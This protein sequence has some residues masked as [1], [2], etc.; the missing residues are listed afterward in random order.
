MKIPILCIGSLK[1]PYWR[2]AVAEYGKRLRR[3]CALEIQELPEQKLPANAGAAEEAAVIAA[4]S[5]RLSDKISIS[6][7]AHVIA[8]DIRGTEWSSTEL[9][10]RMSAWMLTGKSELI[11]LIGGSLGLSPALLERADD[12]LS[13]SPM[14]FPHQLMRVLLLEQV[15]RAFKINNHQPYHK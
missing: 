15:Y 4:E 12:R 8:P 11:F 10:H 9:A 1:E 3:F 6:P 5:R 7:Q 14:T 13:F 2:D